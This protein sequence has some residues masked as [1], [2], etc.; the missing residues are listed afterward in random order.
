MNSEIVV[1]V[2]PGEVKERAY[3]FVNDAGEKVEGTTLKQDARLE[4][5]GYAYPYEVRLEKGQPPF[6][7]GRYVMNVAKMLTV[8]K[9]A[10][11]FS[12]YPVLEPAAAK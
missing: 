5:G 9:G 12:K 10:H 1:V 4:S 6:K 8:N 3:S 7:P 11:Q 2:E